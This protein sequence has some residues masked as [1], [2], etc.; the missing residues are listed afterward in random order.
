MQVR[1][2]RPG[3]EDAV[4][5]LYEW[6]FA[7]PGVRPSAWEPERARA[8]LVGAMESDDAAVLVADDGGTLAGLCTAYI[9]L[10]SVRYGRRCWVEDLAVA[11]DRRSEG[12][13]AALL[14]AAREWARG[15]GA[16]HLEL[17]TGEGRLD[18]QRFYERE[19]PA[20]RSI[21]Y[22]WVLGPGTDATS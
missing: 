8:A 3:E 22:A 5:T 9:D 16:T 15:R 14:G 19:G 18:A 7:P 21:G 13:E 17:D 6:L 4:L 11:P 10:E 1:E 12:I 2:A 20:W